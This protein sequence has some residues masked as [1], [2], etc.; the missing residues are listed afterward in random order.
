M[1]GERTD[2]HFYDVILDRKDV[3][4]IMNVINNNITEESKIREESEIRELLNKYHRANM[5]MEIENPIEQE[6]KIIN[7]RLKTQNL[8]IIYAL[9]FVLNE[10][11]EMPVKTLFVP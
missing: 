3:K 7:R 9:G 4:N 2:L 11:G 1:I 10:C 8:A 5:N 6:K